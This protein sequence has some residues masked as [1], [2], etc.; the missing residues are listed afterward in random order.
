MFWHPFAKAHQIFNI[1]LKQAAAAYCAKQGKVNVLG[2]EK[3]YI[4]TYI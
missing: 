2:M 1:L 4:Y 3:Y